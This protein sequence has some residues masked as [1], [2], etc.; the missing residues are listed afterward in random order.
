MCVCVCV[1]VRVRARARVRV[2]NEYFES[3]TMTNEGSKVLRRFR[4][5][6]KKNPIILNRD[7]SPVNMKRRIEKFNSKSLFVIFNR[8]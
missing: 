3:S 5:I 4:T 8:I 1:C 6:N 2:I 7:I